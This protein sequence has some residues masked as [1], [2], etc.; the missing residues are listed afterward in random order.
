[1]WTESYLN[2]D[3]KQKIQRVVEYIKAQG[4]E[5]YPGGLPMTMTETGLDLHECHIQSVLKEYHS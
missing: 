4:L 3:K 5:K 2:E 1:M